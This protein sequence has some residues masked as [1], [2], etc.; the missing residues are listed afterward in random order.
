MKRGSLLA[1]LL[2]LMLV[3]PAL[4]LQAQV[5]FSQFPTYAG[6]GTIFVADFNGD[7]KPDILCSDG[8]LNLGNGD[9]TFRLGTPVSTASGVPVAV[10]DFNGDGKIDIL[11]DQ[12]AS[13]GAL[14]VLLG[15][16]D[17][18]F[19]PAIATQIVLGLEGAAIDLNSDGKADVVVFTGSSLLVYLG[20]GD[21]TFASAVSY[22]LGPL[23]DSYYLSML[24][25]GDFNG[26]D[27]I[28]IVLTVPG[29][30]TVVSPVGQEIVLLGNGDGTFQAA[31]TSTGLCYPQSVATGDF[32]GDGRLDLAV[33]DNCV[34]SGKLISTVYVLPGN[35]DGTFQPPVASFSGTGSLAAADVNG[36]GKMDLILQPDSVDAQI[37]LGNGDGTFTN[38]SNYT[39]FGSSTAY[40]VAVADFNVDGHLDIAAGNTV[41][42]GNGDGTFQGTPLTVLTNSLSPY[43]AGAP[44]IGRFNKNGGPEVAVLL[45]GGVSILANDGTGFLALAH[46]YPLQL[47]EGMGGVNIVVGD[48]NGDG[49]LDL[50][51]LYIGPTDYHPNW[52]IWGYETLLG[53]GDGTF[54]APVDHPT[55]GGWAGGSFSV[56]LADFNGDGKLD[57]ALT[58]GNEEGYGGSEPYI[59]V[60][61]GQGDGSFATPTSFLPAYFLCAADFNGDGKLDIA[62]SW[63]EVGEVT[64]IMFG[65][66]DGTFQPPVYPT[67]LDSFSVRTTA[68]LNN[69]GRPDLVSNNQVALGK[70]DGTF[71]LLPAVFPPAPTQ[72][73]AMMP[74]PVI[75]DFNG[76]GKLDLFVK[77]WDA[78]GNFVHSG[79]MLGN[80]DGTFGPMIN[81]PANGSFPGSF[82]VADINGD[83]R[84]DIVFQ[85]PIG[86]GV[87]FNTTPPGFELSASALSPATVTPADSAT[88]TVT[89]NPIFGFNSTVLLSC[90]G[91]PSGASCAFTLPTIA[92][93]SGTSTLTI[94]TTTSIAAGTYPV[95]VQGSA[96]TITN[97]TTLS[98][99]VQA[100]DFSVGMAS[101]T[102]TSQTISAGQTANFNLVITPS[103]S[104]T[105][106]V[107]LSCVITP[108]VTP[109]PTCTLSSSSVQVSGSSAQPVT[110]TVGTTASV[111]TG[112]ASY[113]HFPP[114]AMPLACMSIL[115]SLG[116]L[117]L[118]KRERLPV[119]AAPILVL[120]LA[121][122]MS[123]GGSGSTSPHITPGTPTGTYTA[124][125]TA[126][127]GSLSHST[128]LQLVVQ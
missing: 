68:D 18:T 111:T 45:N 127:S 86:V 97:S 62:F 49:N 84:P 89:V 105:G 50:I 37:Y 96:G 4:S 20:K 44:V 107:N 40:G 3:V 85:G 81:L 22:S 53:N 27:R 16:G 98:L 104:F 11:E 28:D 73:S 93:S 61:L 119:V 31:K 94:T 52:L 91:L 6:S 80:G 123:C 76:D 1:V 117:L 43:G 70:G 35:G 21:G 72:I 25:F 19:Q 113:P 9:G 71:T 41:L 33:V 26:D 109:A 59:T 88:S 112:A 2:S 77:V 55:Q 125:V 65:N 126:S 67:D 87:L 39:Y 5:S 82:L 75:A 47:P 38:A 108:V 83:G 92:N 13:T 122:C 60:L 106:E 51:V 54:Q 69:D 102:P 42:L 100:P 115:L 124:T 12:A 128:D 120:A 64:G 74:G 57:L 114:A 99:V 29:S 66:G 8:T 103:G 110:V 46:T 17:G 116:C 58:P 56:A 101:G 118:R 10:A 78:N 32:N 36:D 14:F 63:G 30:V 7:G 121:F 95:Q 34:A 23:G 24:S 79:I 48:F 15:N 90:A